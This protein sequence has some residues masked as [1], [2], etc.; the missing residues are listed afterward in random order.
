MKRQYFV[1][2]FKTEKYVRPEQVP[3]DAKISHEIMAR[4]QFSFKTSIC[5]VVNIWFIDSELLI[6][7]EYSR[8]EDETVME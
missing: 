4:C 5:K 1:D 6:A 2:I 7:R 8:H 3:V